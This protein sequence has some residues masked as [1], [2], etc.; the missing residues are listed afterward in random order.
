MNN[1]DKKID[2]KIYEVKEKI[3]IINENIYDEKSKL[4]YYD[5]LEERFGNV[6][7]NFYDIIKD[8][9]LSIKG[10][11]INRIIQNIDENNQLVYKNIIFNIEKERE[12]TKK[13]INKMYDKKNNLDNEMKKIYL[14]SKNKENSDNSNK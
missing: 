6:K 12:K 8:L 7:K 13:N 14:E 5:D 2:N 1:S 11:R 4:K 3:N 9:K 10:K